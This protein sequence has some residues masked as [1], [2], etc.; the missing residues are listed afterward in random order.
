M[1]KIIVFL[2]FLILLSSIGSALVINS[3]TLGISPI[4]AMFFLMWC[5][6]LSAFIANRGF[7]GFGWRLP[8]LNWILFAYFFPIAYSLLGYSIIWLFG[9][10]TINSAYVFNFYK[11]VVF[12]TI[13]NLA[14]AAGEEIGWRGFL[15]PQLYKLTSFT[16]TGLISGA[17]WALWHFPL[18]LSSVYMQSIPM[19]ERLPFFFVGV[20]AMGFS[21]AFFR[22]KSGSVWTTVILH[23]SHNLY[24]QRLFDPLTIETNVWSK[25][26]I[27]E[28]GLVMLVIFLLIA[29]SCSRMRIA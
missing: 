16:A 19:M 27:G 29:F 28:T 1:K 25:Y 7:R 24:I 2:V 5:P 26:M 14:F 15:V 18:L 8:K 3:K 10:G 13:F 6:A 17:I 22:L 4:V 12:G 20:L 21:F 9:F 23:A 11:L